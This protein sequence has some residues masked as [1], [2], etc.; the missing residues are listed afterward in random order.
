MEV[1]RGGGGRGGTVWGVL[2]NA[3]NGLGT[4]AELAA[5]AVLWEKRESLHSG[6]KGGDRVLW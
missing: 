6:G 3:A 4:T 1:W 2:G 5:A